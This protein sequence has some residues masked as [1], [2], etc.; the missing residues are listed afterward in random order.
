MECKDC[1]SDKG[2]INYLFGLPAYSAK[3]NPELYEKNKILSQIEENYKI[4]PIRNGWSDNFYATN[5]HQ[6]LEDEKNPRFKEINYYSLPQQYHKTI[7]DFFN[8]MS[9]QKNIKFSYDIANY[10]CVRHNSI[11]EPHIHTD[12]SFSLVHYISFD[13]EQHLPT[14]FKSPYYFSQLLPLQNSLQ[15]IFSNQKENS[16]IYKDWAINTEEDDIIIVPAVL[17]HCVRNLDSKK[18]RITIAVNIKIDGFSVFKTKML[19]LDEDNIREILKKAK[20]NKYVN[21]SAYSENGENCQE[22]KE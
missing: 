22:H 18:S 12:C 14:I 10:S 4:S 3:I 11:M 1:G 16:W 15:N 8:K 20:D 2:E 5:I 6:S 7:T 17:E 21:E 19:D 13:K 9:L